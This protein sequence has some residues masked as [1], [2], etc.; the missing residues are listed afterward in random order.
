[1]AINGER[2]IIFWSSL[3][4]AT[5]F[6]YDILNLKDNFAGTESLLFWFVLKCHLVLHETARWTTALASPGVWDR[7][8]RVRYNM[9][10]SEGE[11]KRGDENHNRHDHVGGCCCA[12]GKSVRQSIRVSLQRQV[13]EM[14]LVAVSSFLIM[15]GKHVKI[16]TVDTNQ[17]ERDAQEQKIS[18]EFLYQYLHYWLH[19]WCQN[20]WGLIIW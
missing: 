14:L 11:S 10:R 12:K 3:N 6:T 20:P 15:Y 17:N 1:M 2:Q 13:N 18:L 4:C 7:Q 9:A 5:N 16:K 19:S 8:Q